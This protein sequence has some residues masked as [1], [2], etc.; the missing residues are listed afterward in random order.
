M[1]CPN[2][3]SDNKEGAKFCNECGFPLT[4]RMAAV[5]AASTS[6]EALRAVSSD[7]TEEAAL[8]EA[9][10][11]ND[12]SEEDESSEEVELAV[13]EERS[14]SQ[15]TQ[16]AVSRS[17]QGSGP[18]DPSRLPVIGI[19]GVDVDEDGNEFTFDDIDINEDAQE[20]PAGVEKRQNLD[21]SVTAD[22]S[23]LDECLVD[24][25]YVPPQSAW[26]SGGTMEMPRI[27]DA[28]A[29]K[30]KEFRAP[31]PNE[32]KHSKGRIVAIVAAVL[33]VAAAVAVGV[34]Y[35]MELWGGK[36]LPSVVG[37][38]Q[39][40]ATFQ[41]EEKGFVVRSVQVK[42]DEPE[43]LVLFMDPTGGARAEKGT[44]VVLQV[45]IPRTIPDVVGKTR[46][47]AGKLLNE[48]GFDHVAFAEVKSD[49]AEGTV[50]SLE[51]AVGQK[52][53]A[54]TPIEVTV[55]VP[56][57]VPD[58]IGKPNAE[59]VAALEAASYKANVQYY[60]TEEVTEGLVVSIDPAAG[61]K[62][63]SGSTVT[64][65]VAVSRSSVLV[66]IAKD[67]LASVGTISL[68]GTTY[69]IASVDAVSYTG[70]NQTSF[71]ITGRAV[72][73]LDGETVTGSAKQKSGTITWDDA[74]NIVSIA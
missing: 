66:P 1:I 25:G 39:A 5:A 13:N 29:P 23:G 26:R 40:D 73:T 70:H 35:Q 30:Q 56:Y 49:N 43:G 16:S 57:T 72:T 19:V 48:A 47:E 36:M 4:G 24:A 31:D 20:E 58:V 61:A 7:T 42:S 64:M 27:E 41:L 52:A 34:T 54:S 2:C 63:A 60:Y 62:L 71:T 50:L 32:K 74:N 51:P 38:T 10:V 8:V 44:E 55:A 28:P 12:S 53:K 65:N 46:D 18:L 3:Q 68:G 59:A 14:A 69:R 17:M 15:S 6:D 9:A 22:L 37:M 67:Y 33:I 11:I 21:A 45:A